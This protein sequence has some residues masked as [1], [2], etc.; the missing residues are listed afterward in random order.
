MLKTIYTMQ[1]GIAQF[2]KE[3][4]HIVLEP[5]ISAFTWADF[6]RAADIIRVGEEYI[7]PLIPKI[8]SFFPFFA[9]PR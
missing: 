5:D 7:E 4:A 1:Y 3:P 9:K 2:R 8:K 6:H